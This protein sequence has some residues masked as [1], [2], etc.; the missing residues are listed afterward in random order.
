MNAFGRLLSG[1]LF[2]GIAFSAGCRRT[3][4]R[5]VEVAT[6]GVRCERCADKVMRALKA[7]PGIDPGESEVDLSQGVTRVRYDS[8]Q[9]ALKNIEFAITGAGFDANTY[10][11]DAEARA[12]LPPECREHVD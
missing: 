9:L 3:D 12:A 4:V 2:L 5:V 11:A 1:L 7:L 6:P 10:P 8:M